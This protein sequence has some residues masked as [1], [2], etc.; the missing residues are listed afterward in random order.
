MAVQAFAPST[1]PCSAIGAIHIKAVSS[2]HLN[3]YRFPLFKKKKWEALAL[4]VSITFP[5]ASTQAQ[6]MSTEVLSV[7]SS[8]AFGYLGSDLSAK[9][10]SEISNLYGTPDSWNPQLHNSYMMEQSH[11]RFTMPGTSMPRKSAPT[12]FDSHMLSSPP[13][14]FIA[15]STVPQTQDVATISPLQ[16]RYIPNDLSPQP[17]I[18]S[19]FD[20]PEVSHWP[21]YPPN[22][23]VT[24]PCSPPTDSSRSSHDPSRR[25]TGQRSAGRKRKLETA[26]D[27]TPRAIYLEKNRK[28]ASK[29]RSKQKQQQEDLVEEARIHERRNKMLKAEVEMLRNDLRCMMDIIGQHTNCSDSRLLRYVQREADRLAAGQNSSCPI[30]GNS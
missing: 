27:G 5:I 21:N 12:R 28:A 30:G 11:A 9:I 7:Q 1:V 23:H 20:L 6:T 3:Y 10:G 29:C 16:T 14:T 19:P 24:L 2:P 13:T 17:H 26:E 22:Q 15:T 4:L 18:S 25:S 8:E